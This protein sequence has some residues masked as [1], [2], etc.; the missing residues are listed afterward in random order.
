MKLMRQKYSWC[1]W[2][3]NEKLTLTELKVHGGEKD[4]DF[5]GPKFEVRML[6]FC[7]LGS[8]KLLK[9]GCEMMALTL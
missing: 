5:Q 8:G 7:L 9:Q 2:R 6:D 4:P 3:E 1:L